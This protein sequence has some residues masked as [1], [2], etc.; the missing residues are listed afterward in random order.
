MA[1]VHELK[2][3]ERTAFEVIDKEDSNGTRYYVATRVPGGWIYETRP[4]EAI[5]SAVFVPYSAS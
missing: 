5:C 2:M 1:D 3:H 4:G